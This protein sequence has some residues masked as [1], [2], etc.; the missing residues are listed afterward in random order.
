MLSSKEIRNIW[1]KYFESKG[2]LIV[3][4][5]SLVP[6]NDPSL[7]WINS[8]VATLKDYFSGKKI[9]PKNRLTNS[10]KSLRTNDIENVGVTTRH[11]T[12]FE[13]L[14]NF[15]IGDYFKP[16]AIEMAYEFIFDVL[17]F[18]KDKIYFTYFEED[19]ETKEKWLS[20]GVDPSHLIKGTRDTNFW[21][22]G[23]G[24]CGPCTEIFYDRGEKFDK[25]G[26]ELLKEDIENDRFI[27]IWNVVFSQFNN[28]GENNYTE[29]AQKNIDTGAGFERL[30]SIL[31][32]VPTNFD[33]DLFQ[34]II[35]EIEK[36]SDYKYDGENYFKKDPEQEKINIKF[37]IIADHIRAIVNAINDGVEPS[38]VSRGY[39]IRRL[40]RRSYRS[41]LQLG[42]KDKTFLYTLTSVVKD[43]LPYDIDVEKVS[44]IIKNEEIL[45]SQTIEQ[46]Q[47]LLEKE[48]ENNK[49]EFDFAV[50]FKLFETFGFPIE[51]TQEILAEK[52]V[53]LDIKQFE[54][55]KE[56]HAEASRGAKKEGMKKVVNSLALVPGEISK[57]I[58]YENFSTKAKIVFLANSEHEVEK[59]N[60]DEISYVIFDQT[61]LYATGGGQ[62]HDQGIVIQ[63]GKEYRVIEIFK[64]KYRNNVHIIKGELNKED[65]VEIFVL[66]KNRLN[67]ERNHSSTHL[68]FK[69]LRVQYGDFIKQLGSDNNEDRLTFD[70]PLDSKPTEQEIQEI[71]DRIK[72]YIASATDRK[73]LET[74]IKEAEKMNAIMT[75]EET[76]YMDPEKVR[77]VEFKNITVD[78][79]GGTHIPNTEL[80]QNFK[81]TNVE[82]KGTGVYR[83]RA[84]TSDAVINEYIKQEIAKEKEL[85]D[86]I[87]EKNKKLDSNYKLE[88]K[89]VDYSE[90]ELAELKQLINKA[91]EDNKELSKK[92]SSFDL[93]DSNI[94][95]EEINGIQTY[96]NLEIPAGAL[97]SLAATL[98]EKHPDSLIVLVSV[99]EAK[100]LICVASKKY[101][102]KEFLN[103]IFAVVGGNG[104]GNA[105]ISQGSSS[106]TQ[107]L[108]SL[109]KQAIK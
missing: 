93:D 44:E 103:K 54:I 1:L 108:E 41:G 100:S 73:Y 70:F 99:S 15:S 12:M 79:C 5:K 76:E 34:P 88:L 106:T 20:L 25:R 6:V 84:I 59:T 16:E 24:P 98:R 21:D 95:F 60:E 49:K 97:K 71:E 53:S 30:V 105:I 63:N 50:A 101:D 35:K 26:I 74:S 51:L 4:T 28:D 82:N 23:S 17:K 10:Q 92:E 90:K 89:L 2:H 42:I 102:S 85:F 81:I 58:G 87:V 64:D 38:N 31:Q 107:N 32:D 14:G 109:I 13:M 56:K 55:Y 57:F 48:L 104:G 52:G 96:L 7:L 83:I 68:L 61:V 65:E 39:I 22:V 72:G 45:F 43:S 19:Q 62:K 29:L 11:H 47:K 78:L 40:I 33:T 8:G 27:E 3:E 75:L 86:A 80:I 46:G 77:L 66:K 9:P 94:S 67:L 36:I 18:D 91:R 37:K 69:S